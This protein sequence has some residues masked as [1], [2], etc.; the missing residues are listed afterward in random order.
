MVYVY[1]YMT[2]EQPTTEPTM[3][4]FESRTMQ[5]DHLSLKQLEST[6]FGSER[7]H[8]LYSYNS[9]TKLAQVD[10]SL[11]FALFRGDSTHRTFF[12]VIYGECS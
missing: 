11:D 6:P 10:G 4:S 1:I 8:A 9:G 3:G 12:N 5:I 7:L 2:N